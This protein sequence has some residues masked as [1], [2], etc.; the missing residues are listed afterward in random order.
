MSD[1][2]NLS[3]VLNDL[4]GVDADTPLIFETAEG[5]I[6]KGYHVTE[7]KDLSIRSIDCGGRLSEW[8]ETQIQLLDGRDGKHMTVGTLAGIAAKSIASLPAFAETPLSFEFAHRNVGF[9]RYEIVAMQ[10]SKTET[11]FKLGDARA[12]C[13]VLTQPAITVESGASSCCGSSQTAKQPS[14]C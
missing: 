2:Q 11:R 14:C 8:R 13:K 6:G 5:D 4:T 3:D 12:E 10:H 1:T 9:R 7:L